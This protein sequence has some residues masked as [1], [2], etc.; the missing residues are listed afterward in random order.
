MERVWEQT[1]STQNQRDFGESALKGAVS[2]NVVGN[3]AKMSR[4]NVHNRHH[5]RKC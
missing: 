3:F 5:S 2:S 1:I 4:W